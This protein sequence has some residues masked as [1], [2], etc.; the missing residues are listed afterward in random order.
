MEKFMNL[1][2]AF[3]AKNAKCS[4]NNDKITFAI[5]TDK[6]L[7]EIGNLNQSLLDYKNFNKLYNEINAIYEII[8]YFKLNNY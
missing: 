5:T 1:R 8:D 2:T 4:F 3:G 7:F 6:N